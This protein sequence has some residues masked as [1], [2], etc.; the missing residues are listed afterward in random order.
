MPF[1]LLPSHRGMPQH[2]IFW[3]AATSF[4]L[5]DDRVDTSIRVALFFA[6]GLSCLAVFFAAR[7]VSARTARSRSRGRNAYFVA[8]ILLLGL[9]SF[10]GAYLRSVGGLHAQA[11]ESILQTD[12]AEA[13]GYVTNRLLFV[14]ILLWTTSVALM[15]VTLPGGPDKITR[16][17][18]LQG[19][20][21][22]AGLAFL[23]FGRGIIT[24]PLAVVEAYREGT[25]RL[26]ESALSLKA[27]PLLPIASAFK[28]TVILVIGES[29]SRHHMALYGY[30][31]QT[32]PQLSAMRGELAVFEDVISNHSSTI[33]S[34]VGSFTVQP[35]AGANAKERPVGVLQLAQAAGFNTSWLS[36]QNE[37]GIWDNPVTIL[38]N[39][40]AHVRFHDRSLGNLASRR[41]FDEAMLPS[42]DQALRQRGSDRRLIVVHLQST[43]LPYCSTKP[44]DFNPLQERFGKR[45]YGRQA[46]LLPRLKLFVK[47]RSRELDCYDNGVRY[48]DRML[49]SI[50]LRAKRLAGP[51]AVLYFSD[52]GQAPLLA[53]GH[54]SAEHSA[55]H[56]EI[57]FFLW[58]NPAYR[59][60]YPQTWNSALAN[61]AKPFSLAL[62]PSTL[63]DL[64][65]LKT[66]LLRT[67]D[68]L[69]DPVFRP[70][71]RTAIGGRIRYD[72]RWKDNDY[73]ENSRVFM[74]ELGGLRDRIW[75]HRVNSLGALL[76]A[77]RTFSGVEID[78]HFD[79]ATRRFQVRH[80]YPHIGLTLREMLEWS[81]DRPAMKI[82]L[83]WKNASPE[84]VR[85]ALSE[86]EALDRKYAIKRRLLVETDERAMSPVLG[87]ISRAGFE[88]GYYLPLERI[89][90]AML[91]G[92]TAP[93]QVAA[94]LKQIVLSGQFDA[95]T[96]DAQLQAF[97]TAKLDAFLTRHRIRRYSWDTSIDVGD[98]DTSPARVAELVRKRQ[99]EALLVKFPSDFWM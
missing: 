7:F 59:A 37:F 62:M 38:A 98:A 84:N 48:V 77:K 28:G 23:A 61:R 8:A 74:R 88:H 47:R 91:K 89:Q 49:G 24:E 56:L 51:V 15:W 54:D 14:W 34:V 6:L 43:H 58:S 12:V 69:F 21:F 60:A 83:D 39:Q 94:E 35:F 30:P 99:V 3:L 5:L 11:I 41:V 50:I 68:S 18:W 16:Q 46:N 29:T 85:A 95:I 73:R 44:S 19:L 42:L 70:R 25:K 71:A 75:S 97:V 40:A 9:L 10:H 31:R 45:M 80:D 4:F 90:E 78:V 32:T 66:P 20:L 33:E 96:Y 1:K 67:Q 27:R 92:G 53:T 17:G 2:F 79:V 86:L 65:E 81:R 76:E 57:P 63:L 64:L 72:A 22:T 13:Y 36:N 26:R 93:D 87:V 82:W 52:H 55:Y